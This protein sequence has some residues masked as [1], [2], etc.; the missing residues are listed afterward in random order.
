[1]RLILNTETMI[2]MM[3]AVVGNE[4]VVLALALNIS[5]IIHKDD[6]PGKTLALQ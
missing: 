4:L 3:R 2:G 5:S 6:V 1:M